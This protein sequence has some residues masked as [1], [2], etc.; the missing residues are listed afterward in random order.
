MSGRCFFLNKHFLAYHM[1][2]ETNNRKDGD[3]MQKKQYT[4]EEMAKLICCHDWNMIGR[5]CISCMG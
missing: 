3:K 5:K 1:Q 4:D 2:N